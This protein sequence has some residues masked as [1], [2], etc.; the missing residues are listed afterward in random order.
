MLTKMKKQAFTLIEL[1]VV[2]VIIGILSTVTASTFSNSQKKARD[3]GRLTTAKDLEQKLQTHITKEQITNVSSLLN[4]SGTSYLPY[5]L[6][7]EGFDFSKIEDDRCLWIGYDTT[8]PTS[9]GVLFIEEAENDSQFKIIGDISS[10]PT[11]DGYQYN[12]TCNE[13]VLTNYS[14]HM[15]NRDRLHCN[16]FCCLGYSFPGSPFLGS[17]SC[18]IP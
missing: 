18:S 10:Q 9:F 8:N 14:F 4:L 1:L 7:Q 13:P 6:E 3:V 12:G 16:S 2:I 5:H 15:L 11:V 17:L